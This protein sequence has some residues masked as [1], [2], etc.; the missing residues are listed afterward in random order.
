MAKIYTIVCPE[1][2]HRFEQMKGILVSEAGQGSVPEDRREE[3][4]FRCPA[5]G[6]TLSTEDEDFNKHV[7]SVMMVD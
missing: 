4:P 2:G 1:C 6:F 3:T 7:E 5:C